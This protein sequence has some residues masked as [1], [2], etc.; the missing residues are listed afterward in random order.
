VGI[1][2]VPEANKLAAAAWVQ[3]CLEHGQL[4][5]RIDSRWPLAQFAHAHRRQETGRP[6]GKV[7][8]TLTTETAP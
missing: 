3:R 1:F 5:H 2:S 6:R 8:V 4:W 7:I